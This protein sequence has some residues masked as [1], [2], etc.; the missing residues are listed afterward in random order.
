MH[1]HIEIP[2]SLHLQTDT[3]TQT[4]AQILPHIYT[5]TPVGRE[6]SSPTHARS[7]IG[8]RDPRARNREHPHTHTHTLRQVTA[9]SVH[10]RPLSHAPKHENTHTP[11]H[12]DAP[13]GAHNAPPIFPVHSSRQETDLKHDPRA[14]W[15]KQAYTR[16]RT[17]MQYAMTSRAS[18]DSDHPVLATLVVATK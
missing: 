11:T 6:I 10:A 18:M 2:T 3:C 13:G 12:T 9:T 14:R 15:H 17:T 8:E 5:D 1:T 7:Q 4:H 16:S